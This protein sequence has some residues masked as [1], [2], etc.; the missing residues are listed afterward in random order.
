VKESNYSKFVKIFVLAT[1]AIFF[2]LV[3]FIVEDFISAINNFA[4]GG[5]LSVI[6]FQMAVFLIPVFV[7]F[8]QARKI[9]EEIVKKDKN[10][11]IEILFY[12][13][14]PVV[15]YLILRKDFNIESSVYVVVIAIVVRWGMEWLFLR[16][17][18]KVK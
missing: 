10:R 15:F 8:Y 16:M 13:A 9:E 2:I 6:L 5:F 18:K 4:K 12:Y 1:G 14:L 11:Y 7:V 3:Q 17:Y